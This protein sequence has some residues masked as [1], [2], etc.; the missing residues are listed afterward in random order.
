VG[1]VEDTQRDPEDNVATAKQPAGYPS[2]VA[3]N[4]TISGCV[5]VSVVVTLRQRPTAIIIVTAATWSPLVAYVGNRGDVT[6]IIVTA[7]TV[8]VV[9]FGAVVIGP[10]L[11]VPP[12]RS[13][14]TARRVIAVRI[15][16]IVV[17]RAA[18]TDRQRQQC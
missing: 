5:A 17:W 14:V 6:I 1:G 4:P 10:G 11:V 3:L 15:V 2:I 16:V 18:R 9:V 13:V 7:A 12:G 8:I